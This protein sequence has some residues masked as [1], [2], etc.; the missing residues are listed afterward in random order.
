MRRGAAIAVLVVLTAVL[1]VPVALLVTE[2]GTRW[3]A[4]A[5]QRL[6]PLQLDG[7]TGSL[8]G[9]ISLEALTYRSEGLDVH[10]ADLS[11]HVNL[12]CLLRS[13]LCIRSLT[14]AEL[15]L[16]SRTTATP[17]P[18][19]APWE[20]LADLPS[21]EVDQ[22]FVGEL[23]WFSGEREELLRELALSGALGSNALDL[24][25][26]AACHGQGCV[27]LHGGIDSRGRW[28]I[29]GELS[30]PEAPIGTDVLVLPLAYEISAEGDTR[31]ARLQLSSRGSEGGVSL[32]G[33]L[34]YADVERASASLRLEGLDRLVPLLA[35]QAV[36][37]LVGPLAL[38]LERRAGAALP[39][40][41]PAPGPA[42]AG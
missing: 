26:L 40:L 7:L 3:L 22:A 6:V 24:Q 27:D 17:E 41:D 15:T 28:R 8:A 29:A 33:E 35:E 31:A 32:A 39:V 16:H 20:L 2:S 14:V 9:G 11:A 12:R 4:R 21:V 42:R 25:R 10:A 19:R 18:S 34:R 13:A 1:L 23:R 38:E 30:L 5:A 37:P 36:Y